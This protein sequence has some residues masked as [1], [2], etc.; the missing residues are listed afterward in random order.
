MRGVRERG[1]HVRSLAITGLPDF[2][3]V[4]DEV[5]VHAHRPNVP[6]LD[7][8]PL[9]VVLLQSVFRRVVDERRL[10]I[11][12]ILVEVV[13]VHGKARDNEC[14]ARMPQRRQTQFHRRWCPRPAWIPIHLGDRIPWLLIGLGI[15]QKPECVQRAGNFVPHLCHPIRGLFCKQ[16]RPDAVHVDGCIHPGSQ[17]LFNVG[18]VQDPGGTRGVLLRALRFVLLRLDAQL[19]LRPANLFQL[20]V[21][22]TCGEA[23]EAVPGGGAAPR[24]GRICLPM[25]GRKLVRRIQQDRRPHPEHVGVHDANGVFFGLRRPPPRKEGDRPVRGLE[26]AVRLASQRVRQGHRLRVPD[27]G[28]GVLEL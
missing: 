20:V 26:R 12:Q 7:G 17:H 11:Q 6:E 23:A 22:P 3:V 8:A 19:D 4:V 25:P 18:S 14:R 28:T 15:G 21:I 10:A 13:L 1:L 2:H 16:V 5:R 24:Q 27:V 9:A